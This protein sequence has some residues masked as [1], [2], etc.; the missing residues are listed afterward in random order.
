MIKAK[1]SLGQNFLIDKNIIKKIIN[2]TQIKDKH[3]MEIGPGHGALT[4][5]ILKKNPKSL[6]IIE[7]DNNLANFLKKKYSS[8]K[9]VDI[10][11][12]DVLKLNLEKII[13]NDSIVFG[14]LPYNISSQILIKM[15]KFKKWPTNYSDL[16]FMF[17]KELGEKI[18]APFKSLNYGR[19][20][21]ITS[22]KLDIIKT[23]IISPN[24]F[25]PKP[26]VKS[27]IIQFKPKKKI[28]NCDILK[29]ESITNLF[30]SKKRKMINKTICKILNKKQIFM[31][32]DLDLTGRPS[33]IPAKIY[34]K[35]A[36]MVN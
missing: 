27:I 3:V 26:K 31:L 22:L 8:N 25:K 14:N 7:K 33:D 12:D 10:Y 30:F 17:Q 20:S 36:S 5:E 18:I 19:L 1:K 34:F 29:L 23:F 13:K 35:I 16:I 15:I 4:D 11:N 28:E 21:I 6:I 9:I 24:C 32:K 2:I